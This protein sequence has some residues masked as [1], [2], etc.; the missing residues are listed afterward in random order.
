[1]SPRKRSN[2]VI[3]ILGSLMGTAGL[4]TVIMLVLAIEQAL[5]PQEEAITTPINAMGCY[6]GQRHDPDSVVDRCSGEFD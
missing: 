1:M 4:A 5:G 6:E 3:A 2:L